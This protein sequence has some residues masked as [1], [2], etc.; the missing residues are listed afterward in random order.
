MIVLDFLGR[1]FVE[2]IKRTKPATKRVKRPFV[3]LT[4]ERLEDRCVPAQLLWTDAS[5]DGLW[6]T[7][8]NWNNLL[9]HMH[10]VPGPLDQA[11]IDPG[12]TLDGGSNANIAM[13][14]SP[15]VG[16]IQMTSYYTGTI[17]IPAGISL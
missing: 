12:D 6:N 13:N 1:I 14:V 17:S 4:L 10:V 5:G 3:R 7:P 16:S 11:T 2:Q 8:A 9:T 15:T